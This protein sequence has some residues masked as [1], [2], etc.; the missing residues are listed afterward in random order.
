M[1]WADDVTYAVHDV[2]D[3]Y[4]AGVMPLDRLGRVSSAELERLKRYLAEKRP[5]RGGSLADAAE[6][7]FVGLFPI[8]EPYEGRAE[9]RVNLRVLGSSLITRYIEAVEL[10]NR[11]ASG[12]AEFTI[13]QPIQDEVTVLKQLTWFYVIERPSLAVMQRGQR[14]VVE[15]LLDWYRSAAEDGDYGLFP[16]AQAERV[17]AAQT[18][19]A[20]GRVVIDF[21]AGM[22]ES[23]ALELFRRMSGISSGSLLD[24]AAR[25]V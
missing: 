9:E 15:S 13:D 12:V 20:R 8:E 17:Q 7:L 5:D 16:P 4:R 10:R 23:A 1:D 22:T 24:A 21:V 14:R 6:R 25:M 11:S 18:P 3:F 19:E 2:D